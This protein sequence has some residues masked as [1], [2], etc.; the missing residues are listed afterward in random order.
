MLGV[1][2]VGGGGGGACVCVRAFALRIVSRDKIFALYKYFI[3]IIKLDCV[4]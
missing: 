3:N 1:C 4:L 2:V